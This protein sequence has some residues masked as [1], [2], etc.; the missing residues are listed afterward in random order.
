MAL[1]R[2]GCG[3]SGRY[4]RYGRHGRYAHRYDRLKL[5]TAAQAVAGW[6]GEW[7]LGHGIEKFMPDSGQKQGGCILKKYCARSWV[8]INALI[9]IS[10]IETDLKILDSNFKNSLYR[11][12]QYSAFG[13]S[14]CVIISHYLDRSLVKAGPR[15]HL[16]FY[17]KLN[18]SIYLCFFFIFLFLFFFMLS[19]LHYLHISIH[20]P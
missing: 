16:S 13:F 18:Y 15:F 19:I 14:R 5:Y 12:S 6:M 3:D 8:P 20:P 11:A 4:G 1:E 10:V 7:D 2:T 17:L 9:A